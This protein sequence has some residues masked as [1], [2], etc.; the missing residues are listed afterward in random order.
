MR[1]D[2]RLLY[3][4]E[5]LIRRISVDPTSVD[6]TPEERVELGEYVL[7]IVNILDKTDNPYRYRNT[8]IRGRLN[9]RSKI[10]KVISNAR[11]EMRRAAAPPIG[12]APMSERNAIRKF[13]RESVGKR[14]DQLEMPPQERIALGEHFLRI[15]NAENTARGTA[16]YNPDRALTKRII[17]N[18]RKQLNPSQRPGFF[19]PA[20]AARAPFVAAGRRGARS[21]A[22]LE[23]IPEME[24]LERGMAPRGGKRRYTRRR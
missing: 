18:A 5:G 13:I 8:T 1:E 17:S 16:F 2:D 23:S 22:T 19:D 11:S 6:M 10:K 21:P 15:L 24:S 4:L 9:I 7:G 12:V 14:A 3:D 20:A